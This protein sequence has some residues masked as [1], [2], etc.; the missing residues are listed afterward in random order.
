[1]PVK[2]YQNRN[3]IPIMTKQYSRSESFPGY[4]PKLEFKYLE[5][6]LFH[7]TVTR[8]TQGGQE[9][10]TLPE[11]LSLSPVFSGARVT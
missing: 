1:M 6:P 5:I 10:L 4:L 9:L 7:L 2:Y 11:H 8:L 3:Y